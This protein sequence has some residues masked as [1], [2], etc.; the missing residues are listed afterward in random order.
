MYAGPFV[1]C[2]PVYFVSMFVLKRDYRRAKR[3]HY[4]EMDDKWSSVIRQLDIYIRSTMILSVTSSVNIKC[5]GCFNVKVLIHNVDA[6]DVEYILHQLIIITVYK[7]V[8]NFIIIIFSFSLGGGG[9]V[10]KS[11]CST[12]SNYCN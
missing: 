1:F 4:V 3:P 12:M 11:T 9:L 10:I 2:I 5:C 8:W 7:T 6:D